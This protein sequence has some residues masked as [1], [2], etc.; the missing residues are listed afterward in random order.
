LKAKD[1]EQ[2]EV[3]MLTNLSILSTVPAV[4]GL[5]FR[6]FRGIADYSQMLAVLN[7]SKDADQ[8]EDADTLET[9][10]ST[11]AH[12]VNCNLYQDMLLVEIDGQV[13]G[14]ARVFWQEAADGSRMYCHA[15]FL[16][17]QWRGRGIG[18]ALLAE[19]LRELKARGMAEAGLGVDTENVSG[20]LRLYEAA[21]FEVVKRHTV[22]RKARP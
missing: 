7:G 16:L 13:V 2:V 21:R 15:G 9:L 10:T 22:Y 11:Y 8:I 14:Y 3:V 5:A 4:T 1:A 17:P 6:G 12:L 19:S 18:R 20:A